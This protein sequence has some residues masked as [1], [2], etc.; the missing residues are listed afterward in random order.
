MPG[1]VLAAD[2][3]QVGK[4]TDWTAY[5]FDD[6]GGKICYVV[7]EPKK[8]EGNYSRRGDVYFLITHRPSGNVFDEVSIITGY[9]YKDGDEP[10]ATV[11]GNK[12]FSFYTE[13]DAAWAFQ[14]KEAALVDAMKAGSRLVVQAH[15][16][17]GT[18]TTDTYSLSGI[19]AALG[20]IDK[21]C[22]R[23]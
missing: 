11:D 17:R 6:P 20:A 8:A 9:T 15:S 19:T 22:K 18:L 21:E 4:F 7:S 10:V 2:P 13:G 14:D 1:A 3:V 5:T 12:K 16:Q 23:K